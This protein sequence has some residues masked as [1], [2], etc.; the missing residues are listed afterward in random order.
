MPIMSVPPII[1]PATHIESYA[2]LVTGVAGDDVHRAGKRRLPTVRRSC[3]SSRRAPVADR[4]TIDVHRADEAAQ[5][6]DISG[7]RMQ[8]PVA[9]TVQTGYMGDRS[10]RAHG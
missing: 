5:T 8:A 6:I 9:A 3:A 1:A 10:D 2:S 4:P 7:A